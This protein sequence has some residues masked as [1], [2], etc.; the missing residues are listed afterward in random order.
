MKSSTATGAAPRL[1]RTLRSSTSSTGPCHESPSAGVS[2]VRT[3]SNKALRLEVLPLEEKRDL[4]GFCLSSCPSPHPAD[5]KRGSPA[6]ATLP[7]PNALPQP[8]P[9]P[10]CQ[11]LHPTPKGLGCEL[12]DKKPGG[13]L[14]YIFSRATTRLAA[15]RGAEIA[16]KCWRRGA[17]SLSEQQGKHSNVCGAGISIQICVPV[18]GTATEPWREAQGEPGLSPGP[19]CCSLLWQEPEGN[20][21]AAEEGLP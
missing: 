20:C 12:F 21:C 7:V 15:R 14:K 2:E 6:R 5:P 17:K 11:P 8:G 9:M 19:R 18:A 10:P 4:E 3:K 1:S 16:L 13:E